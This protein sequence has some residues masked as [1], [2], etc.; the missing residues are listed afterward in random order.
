VT[1]VSTQAVGRQEAKAAVQH[2]AALQGHRPTRGGQDALV[3]HHR[4]CLVVV[5]IDGNIGDVLVEAALGVQRD[6]HGS[7]TVTS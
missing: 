1:L 3:T 5:V 7:I 2:D 6:L 4:L